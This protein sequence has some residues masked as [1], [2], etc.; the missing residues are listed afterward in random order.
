MTV[1]LPRLKWS[2]DEYHELIKLGVLDDKNVELLKGEIIEMVPEGEDHAEQNEDGYKYLLILLS[3]RAHLRQ[4]KP[5][6]LPNNSEPEPDI[7]VCQ[8]LGREYRLH[9]PYPENIFWII[10]YS[11]ST[12]KKDLQVK[13]QIYAEAGIREYWIVDLQKNLLIVMQSPQTGTYTNQFTVQTGK[14]RTL[15]FPNLDIEVDRIISP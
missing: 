10:E 5:I 1:E 13:A 8:P 14:I 15:A 2:I 11:N 6:T 9:H 4:A 7:A 12:L 3:D